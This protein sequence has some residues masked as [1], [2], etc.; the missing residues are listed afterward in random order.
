MLPC[1]RH[2]CRLFFI[3][4]NCMFMIACQST[5]EVQAL[6]DSNAELKA[7]LAGAKQQI[8]SLSSEHHIMASDNTELKRVMSI[9]DSEKNSRT[10]ESLVLRAQTRRFTQSTIDQLKKFLVQSNLLDYIGEELVDRTKMDL[11]AMVLVDLD[12]PVPRSGTLVGIHG[13][14]AQ[15]TRFVVNILRPVDDRFVVIWQ[16]PML[17]M[18]NVDAQRLTFP[19]TV[20]V[21]KGDVI[22][23]DF[24]DSV[25]VKYDQGTGN[26][27]LSTKSLLLGASIE[28]SGFKLAEEKRAYS[29]GVTAILE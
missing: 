11:D 23:Y 2:L 8:S 5:P 12:N 15:S 17:E 21:E 16:S 3:A 13:V 14:F 9:L 4:A 20:G 1:F 19:L 18:S 27:V 29:I 28:R 10:E 6:K 7:Q 26:T 24:P 25:G 22:A